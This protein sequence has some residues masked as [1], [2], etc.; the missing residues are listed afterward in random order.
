MKLLYKSLRVSR[1]VVAV[2]LAIVALGGLA[3]LRHDQ[4]LLVPELIEFALVALACAVFLDAEK[5]LAE[6]ERKLSTLFDNLPGMAYR[7]RND[8]HWTMTFVS[9][10]CL[11]VTGYQPADLMDNR[12]ASYA[13]LIH[14]DDRSCVYQRIREALDQRTPFQ[15]EYRIRPADDREPLGL[16]TRGRRFR[17]RRHLGGPGRLH[18]RH[19]RSQAGGGSVAG[20]P[21]TSR[22]GVRGG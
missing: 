1:A 10:G 7:C 3:V 22:L 21:G 6:S 16:G 14:P 9:D 12:T 13:S 5:A 15:L 19:H 18:Y 11:A 20:E 17:R 4:S 8:E 2:L